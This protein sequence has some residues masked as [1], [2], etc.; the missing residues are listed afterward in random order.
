MR[1]FSRIALL[2]ICSLLITFTVPA[3]YQPDGLR[4]P[5]GSTLRPDALAAHAK[6]KTN[7]IAAHQLQ[8]IGIPRD[9]FEFYAASQRNSQWCWAA[10]IQMV[11]N[12][13]G[14]SIEQ[15]QIVARTYGTDPYGRLPNWGGSFEDIT[16]NLNNWSIDN[17]GDPYIVKASVLAG[18]PTPVHLLDELEKKHPVIIAYASSPASGHAVVITAA[19]YTPSPYGPI[20]QS[21]I[22]RD[23]LQTGGRAEYPGA[24]LAQYIQSHWYIRVEKGR[25][26][27]GNK[28]HTCDQSLGAPF[29]SGEL[30]LSSTI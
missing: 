25:N 22:V 4:A 7:H 10:S 1:N 28:G 26:P 30:S 6:G 29:R 19:S 11:L 16:S 8:Y 23:P 21:L 9:E 18:A 13:Y 5:L 3:Q 14:I 27:G 2:T 15:E 20:I 17:N 12:Y 24:S